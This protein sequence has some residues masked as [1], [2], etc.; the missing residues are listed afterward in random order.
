MGKLRYS[1]RI[2]VTKIAIRHVQFISLS[3]LVSLSSFKDAKETHEKNSTITP[4]S[5]ARY[6]HEKIN[7]TNRTSIAS[8]CPNCTLVT[9]AKRICNRCAPELNSVI[10]R[11]ILRSEWISY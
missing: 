4:A 1:R 8:M 5:Q 3:A 2:K 9:V 7:D 6:T 11:K 10:A